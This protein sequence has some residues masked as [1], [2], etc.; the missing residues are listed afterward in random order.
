MVNNE[1]K[2]SI[3]QKHKEWA[4]LICLIFVSAAIRL[5]TNFS[6]EYMPGNNGAFYL[7]SLRDLLETGKLALQD[8]PLLF[9]TEAAI[10]FVPYKLGLLSMNASIDMTT[11]IF[12]SLIPVLAIIPAYFIVQKF[13]ASKKKF[14]ATVTFSAVSILYFSFLILV[15]DFQKNSLGLLWLFWLIYFLFCLHQ[16]PNLKNYLLAFLFF[17]LTGLTHYGC[18]A[19]AITIFVADIMVR[20]SL[21]FHFKKFIKAIIVSLVIMGICIGLVFIINEHR[22]KLFIRIPLIIFEQPIIVSLIK[23]EPVLSLFEIFNLFLVNLV[24]VTSLVFF[25]KNYNELES[26]L[27]SFIPSMIVL[28]LFLASPFLGIDSA[29]RVY[30]IS[31]VTAL[32]LIQF[33]YNQMSDKRNKEIYTWLIVGILLFSVVTVKSKPQQ[34]NMNKNEYVAMLQLQNNICAAE[35]RTVV[36][37]RHGMEYWSMWIFR[38]DAVRQEALREGYWRYYKSVF[39]LKQKKDIS[40]FGPAGLFGPPYSQP[41]IPDGS[42]LVFSNS[43]FDLYKSPKAPDDF[44]IFNQKR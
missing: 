3:T 21:K 12:D 23:G 7:V 37:A 16:Q 39:F 31:Y 34:S 41:V 38:V 11:R 8:F 15:S 5:H 19:V 9:W 22:A 20:Y 40:Q 29:L 6:T 14:F 35:P 13:L 17:V 44:S 24:S 2:N 18:L 26:H 10:A 4:A 32:P 42:V 27:K 28:S 1:T 43:Y 36:V 30:F 33:I 25:I